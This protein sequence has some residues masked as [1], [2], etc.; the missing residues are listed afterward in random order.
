MWPEDVKCPIVVGLAGL[1]RIVPTRPLRR[2]LLSHGD[3]DTAP[4]ASE[5]KSVDGL[6]SGGGGGGSKSNSSVGRSVAGGARNGLFRPGGGFALVKGNTRCRVHTCNVKGKCT[7][8][9]GGGGSGSGNVSAPCHSSGAL[10]SAASNGTS[11][12]A[13][14]QGG[15]RRPTAKGIGS[16]GGSEKSGGGAAKRV[17]LVYW[18]DAGH[19]NVLG[20]PWALDEFIR[21]AT[22]Q[23]GAFL[24]S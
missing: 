17:E 22:R 12:R 24:V 20:D 15:V 19:G 4:A 3:F 10:S 6:A 23:E 1:D 14:S 2:Y 11:V 5:P 7:G 21:V 18:S 13:G 16:G 8:H 9:G